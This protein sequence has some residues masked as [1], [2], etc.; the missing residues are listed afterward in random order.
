MKAAILTPEVSVRSAESVSD[1][2]S[3]DYDPDDPDYD[4][5][6]DSSSDEYE[7]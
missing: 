2:D 1:P 3:E 7:A 4:P 6:L 5:T